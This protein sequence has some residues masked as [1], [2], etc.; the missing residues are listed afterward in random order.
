MVQVDLVI[1]IDTSPSMKDEATALSN[2][3]EVAIAAAKAQCPSDLRV[4]WFGIEG[5]WKGTN[6][7]ETIRNYLTTTC[8]VTETDLKGRKRGQVKG[9][10]AQEDGARAIEDIS[11]HFDWRVG[12]KRAIFFLGD[13]ALEGGGSEVKQA[14]RDAADLAIQKATAGNVAVHTY[15]G[16]SKSRYRNELQ[17]SYAQVSQATGGQAF[18]DQDSISGFTEILKKVICATKEHPEKKQPDVSPP[19]IEPSPSIEPSPPPQIDIEDPQEMEV[20]VCGPGDANRLFIYAG[21]AVFEFGGDWQEAMGKEFAKGMITF[22]IGRK[23]ALGEVIQVIATGSLASVS[24][25]GLAN[26]AGWAVDA[27]RAQWDESSGQIELQAEL[28][29]RDVDGWIHRFGYQVNVL[30]KMTVD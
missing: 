19:P 3:T 7:E 18:T 20:C 22:K 14:D 12:A 16:T 13:E 23:F 10:G 2:A 21:T 17:Q 11:T 6:F 24:N 9:A 15:F 28:G 8:K 4:A 25:G 5:I 27:V 30:A 29:V 1:V 26:N